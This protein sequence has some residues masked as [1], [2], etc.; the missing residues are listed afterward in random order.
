MSLLPPAKGCPP[1]LTIPGKPDSVSL[2]YLGDGMAQTRFSRVAA[3][4]L[5]LAAVQ[6]GWAAPARA[7]ASPG[8][9]RRGVE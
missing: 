5:I 2:L 3:G 4:V 9:G 7:E 6:V 1:A 8:G